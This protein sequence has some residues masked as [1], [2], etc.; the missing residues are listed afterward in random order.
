V[1]RQKEFKKK[2][3][4]RFVR[5][6]TKQTVHCSEVMT[7]TIFQRRQRAAE[8]WDADWSN[9]VTVPHA[10]CI[11]LYPPEDK[12]LRLETYRGEQYFMNK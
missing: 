2:D 10:A 9:R 11:Q 8:C 12:H 4:E 7:A 5:D 3:S 1:R 6:V